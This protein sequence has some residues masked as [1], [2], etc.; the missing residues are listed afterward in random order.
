MRNKK[1]GGAGIDSS[2]VVSLS[3]VPLMSGKTLVR[4]KK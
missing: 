1:R 3:S 4:A 2:T